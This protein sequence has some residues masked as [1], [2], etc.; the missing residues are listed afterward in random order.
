MW[1]QVLKDARLLLLRK[2][3][4]LAQLL[5]Q[6][7]AHATT[8]IPFAMA[9]D[10]RWNLYYHPERIQHFTSQQLETALYHEVWHLLS[11][12]FE[13]LQ[14]Y[15]P[16]VSN[17][18]A[19]L[20]INAALARE[21]FDLPPGVLMPAHFDLPD[22]K[23]AEWYC[24]QLMRMLSEEEQE[25]SQVASDDGADPH[26]GQAS[27]GGGGQPQ[28][29]RPGP[30]AGSGGSGQQQEQRDGS[31]ASSGEGSPS[32]DGRDGSP[33]DSGRRSESPT[34]HAGSGWNEILGDDHGS[35][36]DGRRRPYEVD[37]GVSEQVQRAVLQQAAAAVLRER[38]RGNVPDSF[39]RWAESLLR[40]QVDWRRILYHA[41]RGALQ[42]RQ[43]RVDYSWQ[44]PSRRQAL[45]DV[46]LPALR[47][48]MP[49]VAVV[50]D[51]SGSMS[52]QELGL[53]LSVIR[54]A[55][56][57]TGQPIDV[58]SADTEI[59]TAQKVF[60]AQQVQLVGGGG[61]SMKQAV[62][63]VCHCRER[64]PDVLVVV[65]DGETDWPTR[66]ELRG[67]TLVA[68]ITCERYLQSVPRHIRAVDISSAAGNGG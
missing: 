32:Q 10:S 58:Y 27:S 2:R 21:Q 34:L 35:C 5:L 7:R 28:D 31:P 1:P 6:M 24:E 40:P 41:V 47:A 63:Q 46:L 66:E 37:G 33:A 50:V 17:I 67:T 60:S 26:E 49:K 18:G 14:G 62:S 65:T 19:D 59:H 8:D 61:T 43:M 11:R 38:S 52:A 54:S 51:T 36:V 55:I 68:V 57:T 64:R 48:P 4:Y 25:R 53:A 16:R 22:W 39:L 9:V 56:Q 12:H 29:Q 23:S 15:P 44:H 30:P 13:R 45:T 42:S 20:A 3:P